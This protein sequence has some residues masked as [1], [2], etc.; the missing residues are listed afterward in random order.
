MQTTFDFDL[1]A[2]S[3]KATP[4]PTTTN[5]KLVCQCGQKSH[6]GLVGEFEGLCLTCLKKT[7][8]WHT[9]IGK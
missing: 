8:N 2:N 5:T 7:L 6:H 1:T 3:A 4:S 9:D